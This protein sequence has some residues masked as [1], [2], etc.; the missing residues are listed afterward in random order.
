MKK[1]EGLSGLLM[2]GW[3]SAGVGS[4]W[5]DLT[6]CIIPAFR[7]N[8]AGS[9]LSHLYGSKSDERFQRFCHGFDE[10]LNNRYEWVEGI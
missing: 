4:E 1:E 2:R 8:L 9:D 10:G 3:L 5:A 7:A 6:D